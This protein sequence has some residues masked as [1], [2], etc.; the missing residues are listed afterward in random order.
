MFFLNNACLCTVH[1]Y[2][3]FINTYMYILRKH[4]YVYIIIYIWFK[5]YMNI[6][7]YVYVF[8]NIKLLFRVHRHILLCECKLLFWMWLF[9]INYWTFPSFY[10]FVNGWLKYQLQC[11]YQ[12]GLWC[13]SVHFKMNLTA[14]LMVKWS[15]YIL[16]FAVFHIESI[17]HQ[18]VL[19]F[20]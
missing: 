9:V 12:F 14:L 6:Y 8:I 3:I 1:I 17:S 16:V 5:L 7:I 4:L 15:F 2:F 20:V 10:L 19:L 11:Y 13:S 18:P